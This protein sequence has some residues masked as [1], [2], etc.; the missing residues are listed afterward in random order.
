VIPNKPDEIGELATELDDLA[1]TVEELQAD[2]PEGVD[3]QHLDA[4]KDALDKASDAT[5]DI[6]NERDD[7][8]SDS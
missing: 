6:V 1:D 4:V 7:D 8:A 2:P 5:D 3:P